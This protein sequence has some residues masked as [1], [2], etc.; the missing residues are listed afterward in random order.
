MRIVI[1]QKD[2]LVGVDGEFRAVNLAGVASEIHVIRFDTVEGAGVLEFD[3]DH[4]VPLQIRD[5]EAEDAAWATA[6]AAGTPEREIDI[7]MMHKTIQVA[8]PSER[9]TDF[10]PYQVFVDRWTAAAPP[11][12]PE[13]PLQV[14]LEAAVQAHLDGAARELG[15]DGI[16]TACTYADEPAVPKFQQEGQALRAWR[17]QVWAAC[18]QILTD[19]EAGTREV[20]DKAAL[21]AELP[22][23]AL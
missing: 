3:A 7:P 20:P 22:T 23:F 4:T 16:F 14:R 21:L 9:L 10:A 2:G 15:Y 11:P 5:Q 1:I 18:N 19:V 17:S 12:P 6:R 8:R 13:I